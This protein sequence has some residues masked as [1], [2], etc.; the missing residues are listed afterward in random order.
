[1]N[2]VGTPFVNPSGHLLRGE[3]DTSTM[4]TSAVLKVLVPTMLSDARGSES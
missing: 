2:V 3:L 1:M 4:R